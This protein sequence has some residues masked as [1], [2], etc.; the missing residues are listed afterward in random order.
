MI[1]ELFIEDNNNKDWICDKCK[2]KTY[3]IKSTKIWRLPDIL[4]V[5]I[6]RFIN[7]NIKNDTPVDINPIICF[8]KGT[9]LLDLENDKNY[10]L[11]SM[12]LHSGN[13]YGGHYTAICETERTFLLYD[14]TNIS[15]VD[16]FLE[17]NKN[18]Y[19]LSYSLVS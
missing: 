17:K 7:P 10:R 15:R 13:T 12:A 6:N 16:N 4:F 18:A 8:D 2:S 3:Y 11:S 1:R 9:V 14:D 19:M 5:I